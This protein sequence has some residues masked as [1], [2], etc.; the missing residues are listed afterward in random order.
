M[1]I[2]TVSI[3]AYNVEKYIAG[4]LDCF[5]SPE[6]LE[7]CQ[8]II[9]DDGSKDQTAAIAKKYVEKYPSTFELV[10]K[11]NGGWGST[12]NCSLSHAKG[13]YFKLLDSDDY[14]VADNLS[15]VLSRLENTD[16]DLVI[17][18]MI[19]FLDETGEII[20]VSNPSERLNLPEN[21]SLAVSKIGA[22]VVQMHECC[23]KT[24]LLKQKGMHITE[25]AFYTDVEYVLKG[26][27]AVNN[28]III[29]IPLYRYRIGREGQSISVTGVRKHYKDHLLVV[30]T[31][32]TYLKEN[33]DSKVKACLKARIQTMVAV[34]Y[35]YFL[36]LEPTKEHEKEIRQFDRFLK[37]NYPDFYKTDKKRLKLLRWTNFLLYKPMV[38]YT[39]KKLGVYS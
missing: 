26:V 39:L 33:T 20:E 2:L 31:M 16:C 29:P 3:A 4:C 30:Q 37:K 27:N 1:K 7:K 32:L 8:I 25:H 28:F 34:Q 35:E 5:L 6:V 13:K 23:F 14:F 19:S 18:P 38:R 9:V 24:E 21:E 12:V 15:E 11:E 17:T 36:R 10:E 22:N